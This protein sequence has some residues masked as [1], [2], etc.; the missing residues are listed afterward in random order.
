M[1]CVVGQFLNSYCEG[2][3]NAIICILKYIKEAPGKGLLRED[4]GLLQEKVTQL[5]RYSDADCAGSPTNRRFTFGYYI[6][7]GDK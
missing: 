6:F 2:H 5:V 3:W 4:K 7:I 1:Q